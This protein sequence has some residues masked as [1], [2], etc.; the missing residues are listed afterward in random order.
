MS[1]KQ[2][3]VPNFFCFIY[4]C[5]PSGRD[6]LVEGS[7]VDKNYQME[8]ILMKPQPNTNTLITFLA[9]NVCLLFVIK[10]NLLSL[11]NISKIKGRQKLITRM[12][13]NITF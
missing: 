4:L 13:L 7:K 1:E 9:M 5:I 8:L 10:C 3:S 6:L 2:F 11:L 12:I